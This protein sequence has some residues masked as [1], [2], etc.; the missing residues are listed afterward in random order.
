MTKWESNVTNMGKIDQS[1]LILTS[2]PMPG[3]ILLLYVS[4]S[5]LLHF[6]HL[7]GVIGIVWDISGFKRFSFKT[8]W[9]TLIGRGMSRFGSH[10]SSSHH[11][12]SQ[13][14]IPPLHW[15]VFSLNLAGS[16]WHKDRWLPRTERSYYGA[17]LSHKEPAQPRARKFRSKVP[18]RGL[19]MR[20]AG[21]LWHK[22]A[23]I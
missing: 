13:H 2:N 18:S 21:S 14:K 6:P 23:R 1:M 10:C 22:R 4:G 5:E 12:T 19:W 16:L 9:S 20:R 11:N 3:V 15:G 7:V 17:P 8:A